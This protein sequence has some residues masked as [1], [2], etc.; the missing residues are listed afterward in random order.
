M[1]RTS[2]KIWVSKVNGVCYECNQVR[3]RGTVEEVIRGTHAVEGGGI[4]SGVNVVC[5]SD[6][7]G[8]EEG[9]DLEG[10]EASCIVEAGQNVGNA[11]LGLR[12]ETINSGG[13]RVGTTGKELEL[14]RTLM[15]A[16]Y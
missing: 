13:G 12:D 3:S 10:R 7:V 11:V 14:R 1:R 4:E 6:G 16:T 15:K 2:R 8:S 9:D 5:T